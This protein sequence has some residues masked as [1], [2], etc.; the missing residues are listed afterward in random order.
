MRSGLGPGVPVGEVFGGFWRVWRVLKGL[1]G[2]EGFGGFA[3]LCLEACLGAWVGGRL[4]F[5]C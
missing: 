1:E 3:S 4:L 5:L 2:L